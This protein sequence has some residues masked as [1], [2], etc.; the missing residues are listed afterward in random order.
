MELTANNLDLL[1][2]GFNMTWADAFAQT[3]P[4]SGDFT[5]PITVGTRTTT[6]PIMER[7]PRPRIW[8]GN[9]E[10]NS[11][12]AHSRTITVVPYEVTEALNRFEIEDDQ[13]GFFN[14]AIK[15]LGESAKKWQDQLIYDYILNQATV[16]LGYDG[17]PQFAT[18]H[19]V[20]GGG[21]AGGATGT[22]SN[23]FVSKALNVTN[24]AFV[25]AAMA[26]LKGSDG[27]PLAV[28]PNLLVVPPALEQIALEITTADYLPNS[29][30]T[31]PQNNVWKNSAQ[32]RVIPELAAYP[33]NWWLFDTTKQLKPY[34]FYLR[35]APKFT[36]LTAP[37]DQNVFMAAQFLYG[38]D[39]RGACSETF[40]YYAAAGTANATYIP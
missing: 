5:S 39:M 29:A 33:A 22:A 26:S 6:F 7:L 25:R 4:T 30:G 38:V 12:Y 11:A 17:V 19:P 24:Y 34:A 1:T 10:V 8:T 15:N 3:E 32:V 31:A 14:I 23:L 13:F 28:R 35:Q 36:S 16:T 20:S 27:Q 37:T 9:R 21:V 2:R 40:W 18:N